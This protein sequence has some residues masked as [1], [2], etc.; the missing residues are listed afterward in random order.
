MSSILLI[1]IRIVHN[2]KLCVRVPEVRAVYCQLLP[3]EGE[4][5][6]QTDHSTSDFCPTENWRQPSEEPNDAHI[7]PSVQFQLRRCGRQALFWFWMLIGAQSQ[8]LQHPSTSERSTTTPHD[9]YPAALM[10]Q[11]NGHA[12]GG[13]NHEAGLAPANSDT[14]ADGNLQARVDHLLSKYNAL[15]REQQQCG[16]LQFCCHVLSSHGALARGLRDVSCCWASPASST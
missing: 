15:L 11:E 9:K 6:A 7:A 13:N 1:D 3:L 14:V 2:C 16:M 10:A 8:C 4:G 5:A 12:F